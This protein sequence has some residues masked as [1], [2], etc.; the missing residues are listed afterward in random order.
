M[1]LVLATTVVVFQCGRT[2]L[3]VINHAGMECKEGIVT[4]LIMKFNVMVNLKNNVCVTL[5]LV[6]NGTP[7]HKSVN[8]KTLKDAV[9]ECKCINVN[10]FLLS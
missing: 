6:K 8:V 3:N 7:G 4:V 10:A 5:R 2:G 9:K 1:K